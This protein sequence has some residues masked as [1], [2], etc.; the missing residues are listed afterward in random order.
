MKKKASLL[1]CLAFALA[2][3][4]VLSDMGTNNLYAVGETKQTITTFLNE[5]GVS[6][7]SVNIDDHILSIDLLST[8][9]N[10]CTLDDVKAIQAIYEGVHEQT[11]DQEIKDVSINIYNSNGTMIYNEYE[12]DVSSPIENVD[13]LIDTAQSHNTA[14]SPETILSDVRSIIAESSFSIQ[15]ISLENAREL[16]NSKIIITLSET[17]NDIA[18]LS[19]IRSIYERLEVLAISSGVVSQCEITAQNIEGNCVMYMAGDFLY[20]N[21]IAWV[22]PEAESSFIACEGPQI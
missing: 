3:I 14:Q 20:G 2:I 9:E 19:S 6:Y 17:N 21:C 4:L 7:T 18:A 11:V 22:S 12:A 10:R 8:G 16:P 15:E 13:L 5:R 1:L